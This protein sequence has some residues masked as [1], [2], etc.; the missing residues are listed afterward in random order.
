MKEQW[1]K[2]LRERMQDYCPKAPDDMLANVKRELKKQTVLKRAT[3]RRLTVLRAIAATLFAALAGATIY[4]LKNTTPEITKPTANVPAN[5]TTN[6]PQT[7]ANQ[8]ETLHESFTKA[9]RTKKEFFQDDEQVIYKNHETYCPIGNESLQIETPKTEIAQ[10]E[11]SQIENQSPQSPEAVLEKHANTPTQNKKDR[12]LPIDNLPNIKAEQAYAPLSIDA[13]FTGAGTINQSALPPQYY[14]SI[15]EPE[16]ELIAKSLLKTSTTIQHDQPVKLGLSVGY[17]ISSH[18]TLHAGLSYTRLSARIYRSTILQTITTKQHL[19]YIGL[20]I[21]LSYTLVSTRRAR[22]YLAAGT[23]LQKLVNGKTFSISSENDGDANKAS[24]TT[25]LTESQLQMSTNISAGLSYI[26]IHPIAI[27]AEP[28]L[29]YYFNNDS[30]LQN[31][32]KERPLNFNINFGVR[33][34]L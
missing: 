26:V 13:Y 25:K 8:P 21:A 6:H 30:P 17:P 33:I 3:I 23:E 16:N 5:T 10:A 32:Y 4:I 27:Y 28:G 22:V 14:A 29:S 20:P 11:T 7:L 15:F 2:Q 1:T 18:W 24:E 12:H 31:Y 9:S 19:D 34:N